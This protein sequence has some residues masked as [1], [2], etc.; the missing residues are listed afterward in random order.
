MRS[1]ANFGN[2][3][4]MASHPNQVNNSITKLVESGLSFVEARKQIARATR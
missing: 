2:T 4:M 3:H 1:Q